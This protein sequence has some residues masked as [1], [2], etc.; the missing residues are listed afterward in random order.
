MRGYLGIN[1]KRIKKLGNPTNDRDAV[2]LES[3]NLKILDLEFKH[4]NDL[5]CLKS[6]IVRDLNKINYIEEEIMKLRFVSIDKLENKILDLK[7]D[8]YTKGKNE[9]SHKIEILLTRQLMI[10]REWKLTVFVIP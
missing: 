6:L 7:Q 2:N 8:N 5:K 10:I 9:I 4:C 3:L 1:S